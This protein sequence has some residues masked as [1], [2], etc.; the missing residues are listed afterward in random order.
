MLVKSY[1]ELLRA[2]NEYGFI[3]M[4]KMGLVCLI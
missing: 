1:G 3:T 2:V 4:G